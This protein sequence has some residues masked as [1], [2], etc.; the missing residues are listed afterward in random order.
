MDSNVLEIYKTV[1]QEVVF[2]PCGI[3]YNLTFERDYKSMGLFIKGYQ[4]Y[5]LVL[6]KSE[7]M[8]DMLIKS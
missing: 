3:F 6:N 1:P 8:D 2:R 7:F 4:T 5:N